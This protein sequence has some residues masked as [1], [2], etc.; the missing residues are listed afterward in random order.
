MRALQALTYKPLAVAVYGES[1]GTSRELVSSALPRDRK[2]RWADLGAP[3]ISPGR[4]QQRSWASTVCA[5]L[6]GK[7]IS[8]QRQWGKLLVRPL[9]A[10][11]CARLCMFCV[12][13]YPARRLHGFNGRSLGAL[14]QSGGRLLGERAS[15]VV[16]GLAQ[17][18]SMTTALPLLDGS[19]K[20]LPIRIGAAVHP[21]N[22]AVNGACPLLASLYGS[23]SGDMRTPQVVLAPAQASTSEARVLS[24][25]GS[26][27]PS[28]VLSKM[29]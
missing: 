1:E 16:I 26:C 19:S 17:C 21:E 9:T 22:F 10:A 18:R 28:N 24:T 15:S 7:C 29:L 25:A 20:R 12:D 11:G 4:R 13:N 3:V 23:M 2:T 27:L 5:A 6:D 8:L 14:Q